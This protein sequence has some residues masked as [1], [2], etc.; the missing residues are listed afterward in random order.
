MS[1]LLNITPKRAVDIWNLGFLTAGVGQTIMGNRLANG[2]RWGKS[3]WQRE[4]IIW[5]V[6][7]VTA[8]TSLRAN[9]DEPDRALTTGFTT[10]STLLALNH[11]YALAKESG[12][13]K[14]T[15]LKALAMNVGA[16]GVGFA[17]LRRRD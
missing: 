11:I 7:T 2:S 17:A 4:V 1:D 9:P 6:G 8:L 16:I 10:M 13:G 15:H 3:G 5:N 12:G 14:S